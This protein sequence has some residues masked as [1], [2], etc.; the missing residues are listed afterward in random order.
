M[1]TQVHRATDAHALGAQLRLLSSCARGL[2][3][4]MDCVDCAD[5]VQTLSPDTQFVLRSGEQLCKPRNTGQVQNRTDYMA[6][7]LPD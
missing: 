4:R 1:G 3:C 6:F 5:M 7:S 2:R